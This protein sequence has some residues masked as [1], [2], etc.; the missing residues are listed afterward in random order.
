MINSARGLG[1]GWKISKAIRIREN[2]AE[3]CSDPDPQ[4]RSG[5]LCVCMIR[6]GRCS[7]PRTSYVFNLEG[8]YLY[9]VYIC[10]ASRTSS[11]EWL[12]SHTAVLMINGRAVLCARDLNINA[13]AHPPSPPPCTPC[14]P[15]MH[16]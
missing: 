3:S 13:V 11:S 5:K 14:F 10:I 4:H 12:L 1:S 9:T 2:Q 16:G 7:A 15:A 6:A 8:R